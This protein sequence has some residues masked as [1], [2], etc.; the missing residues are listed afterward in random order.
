MYKNRESKYIFTVS[1]KG[2][3]EVMQILNHK[4]INLTLQTNLM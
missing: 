4:V 1:Q 2:I 3:A